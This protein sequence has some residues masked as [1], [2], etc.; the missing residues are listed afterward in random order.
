[1]VLV[2]RDL[3]RDFHKGLENIRH[4]ANKGKITLAVLPS[5]VSA[6]MSA[7]LKRFSDR[8]PEVDVAIHDVP[9]AR[10]IAMVLDGGAD[11]G[12]TT[13]AS[14]RPALHFTDIGPDRFVAVLPSGHELASEPQ[15]RWRDVARS[16]FIAL[17]G[18]SSIRRVTEAAF[19]AADVAPRIRCE[20]EQISSCVALVEAGH[21]VTALPTSAI[22]MVRGH[23]VS[24]RPL[25]GPVTRRRIG[26]ARL[27]HK[28]LSPAEYFMADVLEGS[29]RSVLGRRA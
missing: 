17:T 29:L 24:V 16:P 20:V 5:I 25:I 9:Q 19:I 12:V 7:A 14:E 8:F 4:G 3:L 23:D 10:G 21:G 15:V 2:A 13:A 1:V 26:I 27:A 18:L 6:V 11:L 22:P 28:T